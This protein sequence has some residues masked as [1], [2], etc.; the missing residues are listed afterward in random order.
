MIYTGS[1]LSGLIVNW[2]LMLLGSKKVLDRD[3]ME[4]DPWTSVELRRKTD[5]DS[6]KEMRLA[7][8]ILSSVRVHVEKPDLPMLISRFKI[9]CR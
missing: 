1:S 2:I 6:L 4:K 8:I 3:E 9:L 5:L 7:W